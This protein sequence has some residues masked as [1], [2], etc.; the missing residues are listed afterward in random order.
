MNSRRN[1]LLGCLTAIIAF[2]LLELGLRLLAIGV[3]TFQAIAL[4]N[5][6]AKYIDHPFLTITMRP[7][8]RKVINAGGPGYTSTQQ[9]KRMFLDDVHQTDAGNELIAQALLELL[10]P[11][12]RADLSD[13]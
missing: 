2:A 10:E 3:G 8:Y 5:P 6:Q 1:I 7:D 9:T 11:A 13:D 12:I 4:P